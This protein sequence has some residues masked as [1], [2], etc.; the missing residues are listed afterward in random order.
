MKL[1]WSKVRENAILPT[2]R[3][4]DAGYDLY[5]CVDEDY[6]I[7]QPHETKLVPLGVASCFDSSCVLFLKERGST[8]IKGISVRSGVMDS[9]Y[10]GEYKAPITNLNAKPLLIAKKEWL[11]TVPDPV[12]DCFVVYPMEKAVCQ[13]VLLLMPEITEEEVSYEELCAMESERG[14]GRL[15]SSGK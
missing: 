14:S 5:A 15:G 1:Y 3:K 8:G 2:K 9:G 11:E 7:F 13:G 4:E 10:R 12:L 6:L